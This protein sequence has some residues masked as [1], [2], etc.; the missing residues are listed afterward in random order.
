[1]F[2]PPHV[3]V[4]SP[5]SATQTVIQQN[6]ISLQ[7]L[8]V[9]M[10]INAHSHL[11]FCLHSQNPPTLTQLRIKQLFL[12][13]QKTYIT[14]HAHSL[15][16]PINSANPSNVDRAAASRHHEHTCN[17]RELVHIVATNVPTFIIWFTLCPK[18]PPS[19]AACV[20]ACTHTHGRHAREHPRASEGLQP[21]KRGNYTQP[22]L[23]IGG[24]RAVH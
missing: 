12:C 16:H 4:F 11:L 18:G 23:Y 19:T 13:L 15:S 3:C 20:L 10:T 17:S 7:K 21:P 14:K 24:C 5:I 9:L 8:N 22:L 1:M 2:R 6:Q